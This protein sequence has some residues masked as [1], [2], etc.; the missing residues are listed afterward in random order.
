MFIRFVLTLFLYSITL[1][2]F[3]QLSRN[4]GKNRHKFLAQMQPQTRSRPKQQSRISLAVAT[5]VFLPKKFTLLLFFSKYSILHGFYSCVTFWAMQAK[6]GVFKNIISLSTPECKQSATVKKTNYSSH[7]Y[8]IANTYYFRKCKITPQKQKD[9]KPLRPASFETI[10]C[11]LQAKS[12]L[13]EQSSTCLLADVP[14]C[15][16]DFVN[17]C[18][19]IPIA[20]FRDC[21]PLRFC[22]AVVDTCKTTATYERRRSY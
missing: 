20:A 1:F 4:K 9:A 18:I 3:F 5:I 15:T 2:R 17:A 21:F 22:T 13:A 12:S 8:S 11:C 14:I 10:F 16:V 19:V 6:T 7:T